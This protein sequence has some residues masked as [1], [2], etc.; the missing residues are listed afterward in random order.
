M[1]HCQTHYKLSTAVRKPLSGTCM[2]SP[3]AD[4]VVDIR[5]RLS[6]VHKA[7]LQMPAGV[8]PRLSAWQ[9]ASGIACCKASQADVTVWSA[10]AIAASQATVKAALAQAVQ[11]PATVWAQA[12]FSTS[13]VDT[14]AKLIKQPNSTQKRRGGRGKKGETV[15]TTCG[16]A[17]N[18]RLRRI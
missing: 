3:L 9:Q 12:D 18:R 15:C 11:W 1:S 6:R 14:E 13:K 5:S 7:V 4:T 2:G 17:E 8:R 16:G 10:A